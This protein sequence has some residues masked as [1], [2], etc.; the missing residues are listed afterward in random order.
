MKNKLVYL[1]FTSLIIIILLIIIISFYKRNTK[2]IIG[3]DSFEVNAGGEEYSSTHLNN[4]SFQIVNLDQEAQNNIRDIQSF[5]Y[6][7]KEYLYKNGIVE[8][9]KGKFISCN[10][11]ENVMILKF[12]LNDKNETRLMAKINID[13]QTYE[14]VAY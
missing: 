14:F 5:I 3:N 2:N 13:N 1:I 4:F 9:S 8:A 7:M 10:I 12:K 11:K 6:K